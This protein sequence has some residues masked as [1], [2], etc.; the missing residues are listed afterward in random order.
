MFS[1]PNLLGNGQSNVVKCWREEKMAL[2]L[3]KSQGDS[4]SVGPWVHTKDKR[5]LCSTSCPDGY[6]EATKIQIFQV[7]SEWSDI[8]IVIK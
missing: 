6:P 2:L 7:A 8:I 3:P 4:S 5:G 1:G